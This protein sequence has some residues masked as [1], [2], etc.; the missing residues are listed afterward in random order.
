MD[1]RDSG[2]WEKSEALGDVDV[3]PAQECHLVDNLHQWVWLVADVPESAFNEPDKALSTDFAH[4]T[5]QEGGKSE[6]EEGFRL[7]RHPLSMLVN[8]DK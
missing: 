3:E 6:P 5:F 4:D 7:R 2:V 1:I 8:T